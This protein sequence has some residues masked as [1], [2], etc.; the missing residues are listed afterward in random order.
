M[1]SYRGYQLV[2]TYPNTVDIYWVSPV[3][4][5]LEFVTTTETVDEAK[6]EIDTYHKAV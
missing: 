2:S 4:G 5:K 1:K 3:T 6:A